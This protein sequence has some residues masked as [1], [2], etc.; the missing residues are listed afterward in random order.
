MTQ[1]NSPKIATLLAL[2][3]GAAG[4][5]SCDSLKLNPF[6]K[7]GSENQE[8]A[9]GVAVGQP[10]AGPFST[11]PAN[12]GAAAAPETPA[13]PPPVDPAEPRKKLTLPSRPD[14]VP[15]PPE[16]E[17]DPTPPAPEPKIPDPEPVAD[18]PA[19]PD[20]EDEPLPPPAVGDDDGFLP[21]TPKLPE[22]EA[23]LPPG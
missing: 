23:I 6:K 18:P 9:E 11:Q 10:E 8:S 2:G 12:G 22:E 19:I 7:G 21:L 5:T 1:G 14:P 20:A 13:T 17:P 3:I 4:L 16:P 15:A